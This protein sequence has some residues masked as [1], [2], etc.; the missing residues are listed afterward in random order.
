MRTMPTIEE[1]L[2]RTIRSG[3]CMLWTGRLNPRGYAMT[4]KARVSR[5]IMELVG[6]K[7]RT[8]DYVLHA[9]DRPACINPAHLSV[10]TPKENAQQRTARLS[11]NPR[12]KRIAASIVASMLQLRRAGLPAY[13]IAKRLGVS[14]RTVERHWGAAS[15]ESQLELPHA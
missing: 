10:G 14:L 15:V 2:I 12:P 7:P 4:G 3:E 8:S 9:C 5:I 13:E 6:Q 11:V 1:L